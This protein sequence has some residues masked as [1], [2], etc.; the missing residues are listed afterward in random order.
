MYRIKPD[1]SSIW[2]NIATKVRKVGY[3]HLKQLQNYIGKIKEDTS[4]EPSFNI[5]H[6]LKK[7][8][9]IDVISPIRNGNSYINTLKIEIFKVRNLQNLTPRL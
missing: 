3:P 9:L 4:Q 8:T 5:R 1:G 6:H 2:F 7:D